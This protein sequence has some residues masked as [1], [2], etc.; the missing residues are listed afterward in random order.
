MKKKWSQP[1]PDLPYLEHLRESARYATKVE[2]ASGLYIL[3]TGLKG[4][5]EHLE[6]EKEDL[7]EWYETPQRGDQD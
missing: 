4:W 6:R 7:T 2:L 3:E 5:P 1:E